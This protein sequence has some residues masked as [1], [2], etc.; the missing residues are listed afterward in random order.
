MLSLAVVALIGAGCTNT[1][2]ATDA[3]GSQTVAGHAQVVRFA[4]CMR[5]NGIREFPDPDAAGA[6]TIETV[7]NGTS[8]DTDSAAFERALA[9]CRDLQ[10]AGFTG[11]VR[12]PEQQQAA[13]EFARCIRDHGVKDFPDPANGEPIVN[14]FKIPSSDT[15]GG[16][17]VLN[18]AMETCGDILEAAAGEPG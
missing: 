13:L 11:G 10:P 4:G 5:D 8:I 17:A 2:D 12:S 3:G 14:T 16:M 7:A 1:P 9:A 15:P 6:L 18:A